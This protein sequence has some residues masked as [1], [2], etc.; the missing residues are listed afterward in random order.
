MIRYFYLGL[1]A[2]LLVMSVTQPRSQFSI[3]DLK[4]LSFLVGLHEALFIVCAVIFVPMIAVA[5]Y[6]FVS[7]V[8]V[9]LR[10]R[11]L[12]LGL[13]GLLLSI[14]I[15]IALYSFNQWVFTELF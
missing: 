2:L 10:Q 15:S 9:L 1:S 12:R 5:F 4:L 11:S 8:I 3:V 6:Y 14:V 7:A 13:P